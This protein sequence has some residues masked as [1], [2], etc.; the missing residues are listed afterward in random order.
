VDYAAFV[1]SSL[2][3]GDPPERVAQS[4]IDD[5]HLLPISAIKALRTGGDMTL[6]EAKELIRASLPVERWAAA[7]VL[8]DQIV[9][10]REKG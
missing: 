10:P 6:E 9:A 5:K 1:R 4:L 8:W 3:A 2:E 7:E